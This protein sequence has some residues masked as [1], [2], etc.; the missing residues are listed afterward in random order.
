[1]KLKLQSLTIT[2]VAA[3]LVLTGCTSPYDGSPDRTG[4]GALTGGA[5]GAGTGALIGSASGHAGEG[6]LIGAA[7]GLISGGLIGHSMDQ[8]EQARLKAQA[9]QTYQRVEQGQPLSVVDIKALAKSGISEDIIISQ[10]RASRSVY[11]LST[12][13][14]ID[15]RDAGVSNKVID[16]MFNTASSG[17][18]QVNPAPQQQAVYVQQ[19]P[20]PPRVE[21]MVMAPGPG[22]VWMGGEWVWNGGWAWR[23]GYWG[24]P[25]YPGGIWIGGSWSHHD[26]GWHHSPGHWRR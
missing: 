9:P 13:D 2:T 6:A 22:Y 14:I 24:M 11:R 21:T 4:T 18:A 5:I 16:F 26:R 7:V 20:P 10:I 12:A 25:P 3:A 19:A 23:G 15:L 17:G 8:E 1:M